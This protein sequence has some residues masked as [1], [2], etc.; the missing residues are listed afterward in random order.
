MQFCRKVLCKPCSARVTSP[1][2]DM[3]YRMGSCI[4]TSHK[5]TEA[6]SLSGRDNQA[7]LSQPV[8]PEVPVITGVEEGRG[9]ADQEDKEELEFPHD[10]LPSLD[11]SSEL[12]IWEC[13][14]GPL[15]SLESPEVEFLTPTE[16]I[17][18][19]L[20][21]EEVIP[22]PEEAE[23]KTAQSSCLST[24]K[25][26]VDLPKPLEKVDLPEPTKHTADL[27][28]K[29]ELLEESSK[30]PKPLEPE[31]SPKFSKSDRKPVEEAAEQTALLK[32]AQEAEE[33]PEP[34]RNDVETGG[35]ENLEDLQPTKPRVETVQQEQ[36]LSEEPEEK[37]T[38]VPP[39]EPI[40]ILAENTEVPEPAE[41]P[42]TELQDC[43]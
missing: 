39:V 32:S 27:T 5:Q 36:Q 20:R 1:E 18:A 17:A 10:L 28:T 40:K 37:P 25:R 30:K 11:F 13:S 31:S 22:P 6:E 7:L 35:T 15:P 29:A 21:P 4:R 12:N 8:L 14:L 38:E 42:S 26:P 19:P 34:T 43:G 2:E 9:A 16:E 3:E 24:V 23:E 33:I 41:D